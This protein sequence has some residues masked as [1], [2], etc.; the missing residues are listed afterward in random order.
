MSK[1]EDK[2]SASIK[3]QTEPAAKKTGG[4]TPRKTRASRAAA[5]VATGADAQSAAGSATTAPASS[6]PPLS[7]GTSEASA[8]AAV[9]DL[10]DPARPLHPHRIWPD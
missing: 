2:L 7:R 9:P 8:G 6:S 10:N 5:P 4:T 1:L 3:P